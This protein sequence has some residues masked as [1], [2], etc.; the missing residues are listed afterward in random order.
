MARPLELVNDFTPSPL[1]PRTFELRRDIAKDASL[2]R[3][4]DR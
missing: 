2:H 1:S 4:G 3:L